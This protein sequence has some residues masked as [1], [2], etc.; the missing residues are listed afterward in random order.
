MG[1]L[2]WFFF[3]LLL[4]M[5]SYFLWWN[6][7]PPFDGHSAPVE[8]A[9]SEVDAAMEEVQVVGTAHL[10]IRLSRT[11]PAGIL[12]KERTLFFFPLFEKQDTT[13]RKIHLMVASDTPPDRLTSFEDVTIEGWARPP[14]ARMDT[15]SEK[16]F[17]DAGY[18]F[19]ETYV[20]IETFEPK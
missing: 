11:W 17:M 4:I 1:K 14:A 3:A 20:L 10:P 13:S 12:R 2:A 8:V 5:V 18:T 15:A 16:A 6:R 9:L 7:L 19:A